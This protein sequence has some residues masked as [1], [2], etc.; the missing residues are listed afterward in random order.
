MTFESNP[1]C[2]RAARKQRQLLFLYGLIAL[3]VLIYGAV[4]ALE[5]N[6]NSPLEWVSP[7][8]LA[9]RDYDQ[10]RRSYGPGDT[11]LVSWEG[12]T[13]DQPRL[14]DLCRALRN[15]DAFHDTDGVWYFDRIVSGREVIA[16]LTAHGPA[17]HEQL[18][19]QPIS[20]ATAIERLRGTLVGPDGQ[21]TGLIISFTKEGL[22]ARSRLVPLIQTTITQRCGIASEK[23]HLAGPVIDGNAV[24][25][26]SGR[27]LNDFALPSA[28]VVFI[29]SYVCLDSLIAALLV[30]GVALISQVATLAIV[31]YSG[32]PMNALLIVL[33]PLIQVLAVSGGIHLI[34]YYFDASRTTGYADAP[35]QMLRAGWQ[36]CVLSFGTTAVGL[37]SL[38]VSKV[39][40]I[41]LFGAYAAAGVIISLGV[42]F[43]V[44][45][46]FLTYW[47]I[48]RRA[49]ADASSTR[50]TLFWSRCARSVA[51]HH[52]VISIVSVILMVS[53]GWGMG[54]VRSSVRIETLFPANSRILSDYEW[55]EQNI[56][57][58][59][60]IEVI[61][62]CDSTCELPLCDRISLLWEI[63]QRLKKVDAIGATTSAF[64]FLPQLAP[65]GDMPAAIY[66]D[67][68]NRVL[69]Y[70]KPRFTDL[71][72]L[73]NEEGKE[74]WRVTA[75][76]S[77][78]HKVDYAEVLETV[79]AQVKPLLDDAS[80]QP[81]IGMSAQF[82]G[83]MPLV[84]AIQQQLLTDLLMSFLAALVIIT[85]V[86]TVVQAGVLSGL[87]AM[88]A[89]VFPI[90]LL[91]GVLGWAE[92]PLDIGSVMTA[93]IA[94]GIAVDD[95]LHYL[96][97]FRYGLQSGMDR[98]GAVTHAYQHCGAAMIQTS[99]SCGLGL[100]VFAFSDFVP[101]CRFAWMMA[102]LL[103]L[104]L[105]GDLIVMPALL[106]SPAGRLFERCFARCPE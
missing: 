13:L 102:I 15:A 58:L 91:F 11:V 63:E 32:E 79:S 16:T 12:C 45:P 48:R 38:M 42:L 101:T 70:L 57:P 43:T 25:I 106:L 33:P 89:N 24:D 81:R 26:A 46:A 97:F 36:P 56:G 23:Q 95:T 84:Q 29:V 68:L 103:A 62:Q 34:N 54:R 7:S 39:T 44:V 51:R 94:L 105:A 99:L 22:A 41:R 65:Q 5:S 59:V 83:I 77:A 50:E 72:F 47:P 74:E 69:A 21:T 80:H 37:A 92:I 66:R 52:L 98:R 96:T 88:V 10:F 20:R 71:R 64:T 28:A 75:Y 100:L 35:R 85:L 18:A 55:L 9:R 73:H 8:F 1:P 86:M 31:Y 67:Y 40:P 104:A 93:S 3:P 2:A 27:A 78:L 82:T 90:V 17:N 61:I 30:F 87:T 19:P 76:V 6:S 14:D 60:P 49:D 53:V 4:G